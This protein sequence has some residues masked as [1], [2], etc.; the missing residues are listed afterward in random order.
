MGH[1][2]YLGVKALPVV[3]L[4]INSNLVGISSRVRYLAASD[5]SAP[6]AAT[7][8]SALTLVRIPRPWR[9]NMRSLLPA[10]LIVAGT[11]IGSR[12]IAGAE[13]LM[14]AANLPPA[15]IG[16]AQPHAEGFSPASQTNQAEQ[17][18]L[19]KFDEQQQKLDEMLDKKPSICRC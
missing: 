14:G 6:D 19:S 13:Q 16:H 8:E 1:A 7:T 15:P 2:C 4:N 9:N 3:D 12:G 10:M 17:D 11:I 5:V 18:R